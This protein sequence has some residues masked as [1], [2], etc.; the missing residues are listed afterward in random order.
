[1]IYSLAKVGYK[2]DKCIKNFTAH[3]HEI[4]KHD[5]HRRVSFYIVE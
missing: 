1:M 5:R 2:I 3:D 4:I